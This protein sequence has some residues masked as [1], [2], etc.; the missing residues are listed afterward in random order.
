VILLSSI[1]R[2]VVNYPAPAALQRMLLVC[3]TGLCRT[4]E[5]LL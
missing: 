2:V 5:L 1:C 3:I 4:A